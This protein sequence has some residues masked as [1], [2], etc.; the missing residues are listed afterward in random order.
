M[1]LKLKTTFASRRDKPK[2]NYISYKRAYYKEVLSL[3]SRGAISIP[4]LLNKN[5]LK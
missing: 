4:R 3:L 2:A 5:E 1:V